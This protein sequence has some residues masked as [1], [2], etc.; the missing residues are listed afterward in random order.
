MKLKNELK[1]RRFFVSRWIMLSLAIL[2]NAFIIGYS[3]LSSESAN[4]LSTTF[5]NF[6]INFVNKASNV[7]KENIPLESIEINLSNDKYNSI[8][9]YQTNEIPLG[10]AKEISCVFIPNNAT[11][12]S[13]SYTAEP[14][15]AVILN[16]SGSVV[17]VVGMKKGNVDIIAKSSDGAL[18]STKTLS[19]IETVAPINYEISIDNN[20][21]Q[22]NSFGTIE[23]DIPNDVLPKSE[24]IL[25]RYY[26]V[27]KLQYISSNESVATVENS[28]VIHPKTN[29]TATITVKNGDYH[30]EL[31]ISVVGSGSPVDYSNLN[32]SGSNVCY[33]NDIILDQNS[34]KN[35]Y[36]LAIKERETELNPLDF[37]WESSNELLA[38]V[39]RHGVLRGFRKSSLEDETVTIKATSKINN[40]S[41]EFTVTVKNQL[42][43]QIYY[44]LLMN[45]EK[46]WNIKS[47]VLSVGDV[48]PLY[49]EYQPA[50]QNKNANAILSN[51]EVMSISNEGSRIMISTSKVGESILNVV[52][53]VNPDLSFSISFKVVSAGV[54]STESFDDIT[55]KIRKSVGHA[56]VF[57]V[58][59][60]FTLLTLFMFLY[61]KKWWIYTSI[62]LVEGFVISCIS[63]LI[64][65]FIPSRSGAFLDVVIDF[66]GVCVGFCIGIL[67][68]LL[69]IFVN[70]KAE[71]KAQL[72]QQENK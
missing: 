62:S 43:T 14:S 45:G 27:R 52:S 8:P 22:L 13:L 44:Y 67:I 20:E 57:M 26:D 41:A 24:L 19:I 32:I 12:Q 7:E 40:K 47:F 61:D 37:I 31:P 36:Q 68:L 60:A 53:E 16:Q 42:P 46:R 72:K 18:V 66:S 4:K 51:D 49:I 5:A 15:D 35:H 10:S 25:S 2:S 29:G 38:R 50:T 9:G 3:F 63:E 70:K 17:S 48:I 64:Q 1:Y 58:S 34:N 65:Y 39:D 30:K 55:H 6:F 28:G 59:Q 56:A 54:V 23:F 33:A 21:I 11:N 69:I 71:Q